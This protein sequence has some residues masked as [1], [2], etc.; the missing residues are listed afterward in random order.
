MY[1]NARSGLEHLLHLEPASS[2]ALTVCKLQVIGGC[3]RKQYDGPWLPC[4]YTIRTGALV[5]GSTARP[6]HIRSGGEHTKAL[7]PNEWMSQEAVQWTMI[8]CISR[9]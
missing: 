1:G 5:V 6:F 9:C 7:S 3:N 2:Q 8:A 4:S